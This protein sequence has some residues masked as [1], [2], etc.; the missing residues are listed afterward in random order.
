VKTKKSVKLA[1][2]RNTGFTDLVWEE[3]RD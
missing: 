1:S 3:I 2:L